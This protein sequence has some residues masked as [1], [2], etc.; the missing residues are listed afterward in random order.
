[1]K[2]GG[3]ERQPA[4]DVLIPQHRQT[5][6]LDPDIGSR[7]QGGGATRQRLGDEAAAIVGLSQDGGEQESRLDRPAVGGQAANID[8]APRRGQFGIAVGDLCQL[9]HH[10]LITHSNPS[11]GYRHSWPAPPA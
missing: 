9:H 4:A 10:L 2:P 3:H 11:S 6:V 5:G 7:K 8:L 1:M